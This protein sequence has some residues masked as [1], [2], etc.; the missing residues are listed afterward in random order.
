MKRDI[1]LR[2]ISIKVKKNR[3]VRKNLADGCSVKSKQKRTKDLP[4][5]NTSG[6]WS[7]ARA[8]FSNGD[9]LRT[10]NKVGGDKVESSV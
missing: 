6:K 3:T 1:K 7:R 8:M 2:V 4:L 5:G 10:V 9:V